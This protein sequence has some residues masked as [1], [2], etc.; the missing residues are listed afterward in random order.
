MPGLPGISRSR[1]VAL[2]IALVVAIA[3]VSTVAFFRLARAGEPAPRRTASPPAA[4]RPPATPT[5]TPTAAAGTP[6]SP[7]AHPKTPR[8]RAAGAAPG[9]L[10][11]RQ[12][13]IMDNITAAFEHSR[14]VPQYADIS[15]LHDGCGY[16]AGWIG[17]CTATGDMLDLV[18]RYNTVCPGNVLAKYTERLRRL[19]DTESD[20]VDTLGAGFPADWRHAAADPA[21]RRAQL[22]IGHDLYLVPAVAAAKREGITTALGIE[23]LFDTALQS[24]PSAHD[25][26]GMPQTVRRTNKIMG[27]NP[28]HGVG[29]RRWLLAYNQ[30][31]TRQLQRPCEPGREVD[32]PDS[33]DRVAA[34]SGLIRAGNWRLDLPVRLGSDVQI[35][36]RVPA[37]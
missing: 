23:H 3:T 8:P 1:W 10:T 15:N 13:M 34:L 2:V 33:V 18:K 28:A 29:E 20:G 4:P 31:R 27:G 6:H 37:G 35:T 19:A 17:F 16:T 14:A 21:F 26:A 7:S 22:D 32:W 11:G 36:I 25:C 5:A 12:V 9:H 30:I 24:G